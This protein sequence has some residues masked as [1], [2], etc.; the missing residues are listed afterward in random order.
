MSLRNVASAMKLCLC[1]KISRMSH[2]QLVERD[3]Q[4]QGRLDPALSSET[5]K[6]PD[7]IM[8]AQLANVAA[9]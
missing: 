6:C 8:P 1:I 7:N 4:V 5:A 9:F 2:L 3:S